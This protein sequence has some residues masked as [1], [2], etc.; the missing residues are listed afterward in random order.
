MKRSKKQFL[1]LSIVL[2]LLASC[3]SKPKTP[4]PEPAPQA[5]QPAPQPEQPAA[6]AVSQEELD[7]LLAEA[8][9]QK[10]RAFDLKLNELIPDEYK[11]ADAAFGE[12][13]T[14]YDAK[15]GVKAKE[16]L[17]SAISLFKALNEK[18]VV[19]IENQKKQ[20]ADAIKAAG[21]KSGANASFAARWE[22]ADKAYA[23]A[24]EASQKG[25]HDAAIASY[26]RARAI[27]ELAVKREQASTQRDTISEKQYA[28][29]DTG[30]F[31]LAE[32]KYAEE[33]E[34][35]AALDGDAS[36][37][38]KNRESIAKAGDSLDEAI[39]R[40]NLVIQKGREGIAGANKKKSDD[41][42]AESDSIKASVAVK[43]DYAAAQAV[44]QEGLD[45]LE[46]KD[47]ETAASKF[48]EAAALF[49]QVHDSAAA[50]KAAADAAMKAAEAAA[51]ASREKAEQADSSSGTNQ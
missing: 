29:W 21:E 34:I 5:E 2:L 36:D 49:K 24:A 30:N 39:L 47:Y 17:A 4:E 14:A 15:D 50:K 32:K 19:Q 25:D 51:E 37:P 40:Y 1:A 27:Y 43:D 20:A 16:Q 46:K 38:A 44:Y 28:A 48:E 26:E 35:Y 6:P 42:K 31:D 10:K 3:A 13:K 41:A 23:A 33:E 8:Q 7:S 9:A 18:G 12:G 22:A 11:T 45:A